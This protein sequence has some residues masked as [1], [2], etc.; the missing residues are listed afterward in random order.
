MRAL[1]YFAA[2]S[3]IGLCLGAAGLTTKSPL[4]YVILVL[5]GIA[6]WSAGEKE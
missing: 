5:V 2:T 6:V 4:L 1:I 3:G